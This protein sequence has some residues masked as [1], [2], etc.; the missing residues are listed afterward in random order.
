MSIEYADCHMHSSFSGDSDAPMEAMIEQAIALG[1]SAICFTEHH[2]IDFPDTPDGPGSTF[3]LNTDSYLYDLL[4]C[5]ERYADRIRILFGVE[6]GLQPHLE[7][8]CA[9]YADAYD[10][11]FI[12]ASTHLTR[13]MDPYY[14]SFFENFSSE[15]E[16]LR[17]HFEEMYENLKIHSCFD[18]VGH[19]DYIAR[20]SP[21]HDALYSYARYADLID[22]ILKVVIEK[23]KGLEINTGAYRYGLGRPHPCEDVLRR[24]HELGGTLITFGSDAHSPEYVGSYF[25]E[26]SEIAKACGFKYYATFHKRS[27]EYHRL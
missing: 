7:K 24:Y 16:A 5:R 9:A 3:L 4:R 12:I 25:K 15:D 11:D 13:H 2:D 20:V 18:V 8:E 6:L 23:N 10:F 22:E 1:L 17:T 19:L 26:A 27:P 21:S 14:P